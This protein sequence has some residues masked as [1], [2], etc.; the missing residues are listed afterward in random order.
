MGVGDNYRGAEDCSRLGWV[1]IAEKHAYENPPWVI[2]SG[3]VYLQWLM[4]RLIAVLCCSIILRRFVD[5]RN[6]IY[7]SSAI[8]LGGLG[9]AKIL[10]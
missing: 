3:D 10:G 9:Y 7:Q 5:L 4:P 1:F 8:E 2:I 6:L